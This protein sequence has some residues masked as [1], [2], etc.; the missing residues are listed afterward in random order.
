MDSAASPFWL[1]ALLEYSNRMLKR[2]YL[3]VISIHGKMG[4]LLI[5]DREKSTPDYISQVERAGGYACRLETNQ[6]EYEF[7]VLES[8]VFTL[9]A[10]SFYFLSFEAEGDSQ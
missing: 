2:L 6:W 7:A 4:F 10:D 9:C 8:N 5:G 3:K 1:C